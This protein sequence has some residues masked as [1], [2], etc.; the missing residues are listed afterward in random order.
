MFQHRHYEA[1]A[2][3]VSDVDNSVKIGEIRKDEAGDI[4]VRCLEMLFAED[5]PKFD[6]V[7]FAKA[8]GRV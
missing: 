1:I 6:L 2:E 5:N 4:I 8:C 7:R 3:I